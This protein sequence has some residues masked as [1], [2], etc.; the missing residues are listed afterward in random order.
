MM[1]KKEQSREESIAL[2]AQYRKLVPYGT[3]THMILN[4]GVPQKFFSENV[5]CAGCGHIEQMASYA[6]AQ[7]AQGHCMVFTCGYGKKQNL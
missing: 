6:I 4:S 2:I 7:K 5:V 3:K 1:K